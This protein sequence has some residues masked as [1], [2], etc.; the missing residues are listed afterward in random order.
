MEPITGENN[1]DVGA[2]LDAVTQAVDVLLRRSERQLDE[3]ITSAFT[4]GERSLVLLRQIER[5]RVREFREQLRG[6][7]RQQ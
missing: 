3:E 6:H 7:R 1:G 5:D 2:W 4:T